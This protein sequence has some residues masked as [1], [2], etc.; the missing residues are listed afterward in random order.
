MRCVP[1]WSRWK[2]RSKPVGKIEPDDMDDN[3]RLA[4]IRELLN[5]SSYQ[6]DGDT[7][8]K[9]HQFVVNML[10]L[11]RGFDEENI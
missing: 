2:E 10:R 9:Y 5:T 4:A 3:E 6:R 11:A 8:P 7:Y 1:R